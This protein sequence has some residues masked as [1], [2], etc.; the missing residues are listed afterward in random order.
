MGCDSCSRNRK[1]ANGYERPDN[2]GCEKPNV[3]SHS[4]KP[5]TLDWE[6]VPPSVGV[7]TNITVDFGSKYDCYG[8]VLLYRGEREIEELIFS[9]TK[10]VLKE[11]VCVSACS[12]KP[13]TIR[14]V[15][16]RKIE[17]P[18]I[19]IDFVS[20]KRNEFVQYLGAGSTIKE[21]T[22]SNLGQCCDP[23]IFHDG[24]EAG[25]FRYVN[26]E[27]VLKN[28]EFSGDP[29]VPYVITTVDSSVCHSNCNLSKAKIVED[30]ASGPLGVDDTFGCS[31]DRVNTSVLTGQQVYQSI[32]FVS[33][34]GVNP[35]LSFSR[36]IARIPSQS[37]DLIKN[38]DNNYESEEAFNIDG[39]GV[40][41]IVFIGGNVC[42]P[43]ITVEVRGELDPGEPP[44]NL[45]I[46]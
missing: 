32:S 39:L 5:K 43:N 36:V 25:K 30:Y 26:G 15:A 20:N 45:D 27:F 14:A 34:R 42:N 18:V 33:V 7:I 10:Y 8:P 6:F 29:N 2:S 21:L 16:G 37:V 23:Q 41:T 19:K 17:C 46:A 4:R 38:S 28:V 44:P 22:I 24:C 13:Y 11:K 12:S 9:S 1:P 3:C 35:D 40:L 31:F